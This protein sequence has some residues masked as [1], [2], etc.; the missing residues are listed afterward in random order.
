MG[1]HQ[2]NTIKKD[3]IERYK[4]FIQAHPKGHFMQSPEWAA[5]KSS[6][7]NEIILVEDK[8]G[9]IKGAMS[10]LIRKV[11]YLGSTMMYSPR[12]PVCDSH[13]AET[14][15]ELLEKAKILAKKYKCYALKMDPDIEIEDTEFESILK[16][17][18]FQ[19]KRGL[20]NYEGI[21][22]RFV[23]RL[24]VKDK[25]EEEIMQNFHH[26]T[27]YNIR[28]AQKKGVEIKYGTRADIADFH[29]IIVDTGIRDKFVVRTREYYE[30]VYDN[31]G[32]EHV[33][34]FMAYYEGKPIAGTIA[35]LYGNKCWYLYGAS[36][37]EHRNIM[38]NYLLQWEMIKMSISSGCDIYDFRGVPGNIDDSNH[39]SGLY[40][41]KVGFSGKFTEFVGMFDYVFNPFMYF[42]AENGITVFRESRRKIFIMKN[43]IKKL[44]IKK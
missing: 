32:P 2:L 31:L 34:V 23:F 4:E 40:K 1:G 20:K 37:N 33:K 15:K 38:P 12:G 7:I 17:I 41:F 26:K 19:V 11:P 27:R 24:D 43:K 22:P 13:D 10:V 28:L 18:G 42:C 25:T 29:N 21:Q 16:S 3:N 14:L 6:W 9:V 35:I 8:D 39:M 30:S 44:V 5:L 36:K